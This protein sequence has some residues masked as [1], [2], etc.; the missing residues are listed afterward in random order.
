[1]ATDF[2]Y[3]KFLVVDDFSDFRS[4]LKRMIQSFG[5]ID[6]D[7]AANG[8]MALKCVSRKR[9]D[10]ILCD[11]NLG[12]NKKDGQQV[13][14]EIKHQNLIPHSTVFMMVTAENTSQMVM[15]AVEYQPDD[16]LI[17]PFTKEVLRS[18]LEKVF[19]KKSN[20]ELIDRAVMEKDYHRAI[21][22]CDEQVLANPRNLYEYLKLKGELCII[23]ADYKEAA[24][25]YER[26]L[27]ERDIPWARLGLGKI[28]YLTR[29]FETARNALH[30]LIQ[31]NPMFVEAYD[32]LSK[33]NLALS[34]DREAQR[35]L[36]KAAEIS[37]KSIR[38]QSS[39]GEISYRNQ[40]LPVAER[41][42]KKAITLGKTSRLKTPASY[43]GLARVF[44]DKN[45]PE[46]AVG[47][48][49]EAKSEFRND[50]DAT[51][52]AATMEAIVYK[53][54]GKPEEARH[55]LEEA[56]K[57]LGGVSGP[58]PDEIAMELAK[59]CFSLG[60]KDK[61]TRVIKDLIRNNHD[62]EE[63]LGKV[64]GLFSDLQLKE[65]GE[66]II[67]STRREIIQLNNQGVRLVEEGRLSEAI[68][69]FEKAAHGLPNN[70]VIN[71]NA[72]QAVLMYIQKNGGNDQLFRN[73]RQFI[74]RMKRVDPLSE[75]CQR[76]SAMYEKLAAS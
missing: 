56:T 11:Y 68:E 4:S 54:M 3:K 65:E 50:T 51:F 69:Y 9:Y 28:L 16:Y 7:D 61:G 55:S 14:E 64:Q 53:S 17:K 6:I 59:A 63:L 34:E 45:V 49:G 44:V 62:D 41:S 31:E 23:A 13:L 73:A 15:G 38:R 39:L 72:A 46:Q 40:D 32:W 42:F 35:I 1:M 20:F 36:E 74:E 24:A 27:A 66:R 57:L 76:L 60:E 21:A 71:A 26:V 19:V 70:K 43:I 52:Q 22:L 67:S 29:E 58:V 8:E 10:V 12:Y 47:L 25:V 33:T 5:V 2:S 37:P 18:R 30:S 75:R 48:L